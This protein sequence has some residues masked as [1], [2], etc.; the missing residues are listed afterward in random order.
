VLELPEELSGHRSQPL[1]PEE[2]VIPLDVH[3]TARAGYSELFL[4][5]LEGL[6]ELADE[7]SHLLNG[8]S[9]F[10]QGGLVYHERRRFVRAG[11]LV[12]PARGPL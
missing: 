8:P 7:P 4:F 9:A 2:P 3:D 11:Q 5:I 6:F 10:H 12:H 1:V